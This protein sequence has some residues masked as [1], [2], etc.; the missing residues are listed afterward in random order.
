VPKKEKTGIVVSDKMDKTVVV[1][2][3]EYKPHPKYKKIQQQTK[4]YLACDNKNECQKGDTVRIIETRPVSK[5]K[6]WSVAAVVE[7]AK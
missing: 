7:K 5:N 4:N 1:E 3:H 2:I 6:C